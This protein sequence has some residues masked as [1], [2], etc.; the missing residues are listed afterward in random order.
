MPTSNEAMHPAS[1]IITVP[2]GDEPDQGRFAR[3]IALKD[4]VN[5]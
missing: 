4:E 1:N 5:D 3:L 2:S